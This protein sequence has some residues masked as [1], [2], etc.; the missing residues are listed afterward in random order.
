MEGREVILRGFALRSLLTAVILLGGAAA[1]IRDAG[2]L[3][4]FGY[5]LKG[6][7]GI[8]WYGADSLASQPNSTF[9]LVGVLHLNGH[10][11]VN[12]GSITYNDAG[13]VCVGTVNTGSS[14]YGVLPD[15]QGQMTLDIVHSSGTCPI[16]HFAFP[17]AIS[18]LGGSKI[19]RGFSVGPGVDTAVNLTGSGLALLQSATA[20]TLSDKSFHSGYSFSWFGHDFTSASPNNGFGAAGEIGFDHNGQILGGSITYNDGGAICSSGAISNGNGAGL[21]GSYSV[22]A[23]GTATINLKVVGGTGTC[24]LTTIVMAAALS[25][26]DESGGT[27]GR[28][29]FLSVA[30]G[31]HGSTSPDIIVSGFAIK[32]GRFSFK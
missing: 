23:N 21:S 27:A 22:N 5:N 29:Q 20:V 9:A 17:I 30:A 7:Y 4:L 3:E 19:A 11:K 31:P 26:I 2:A 14:T 10:S 25:D 18:D 1:T 16:T 13:T 32:V 6:S 12:A 8:S 15:G 28:I 24:P